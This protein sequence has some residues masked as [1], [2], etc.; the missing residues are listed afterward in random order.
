MAKDTSEETHHNRGLLKFIA[1]CLVIVS[2]IALF[3]ILMGAGVRS[4]TEDHE[5]RQL[6][7]KEAAAYI[8]EQRQQPQP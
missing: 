5:E 2:V 1:Q 8:Q 3:A 4:C 7:Y 6:F